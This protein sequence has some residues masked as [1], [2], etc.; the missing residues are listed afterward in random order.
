MDTRSIPREQHMKVAS[1]IMDGWS[2][3]QALLE[4]GYSKWTALR[5]GFLL[6]NSR[7][8]KTAIEEERQRRLARMIPQPKYRRRRNVSTS[9]RIE[10]Q[11]PEWQALVKRCSLCG[12]KLEGKDRWCPNCRQVEQ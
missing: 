4:A 1:L 11:R 12:G 2:F 7:P 10:V 9:K 3:K 8:L 5:P 6:R